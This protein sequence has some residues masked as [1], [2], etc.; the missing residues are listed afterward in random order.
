V[1]VNFSS[2]EEKLGLCGTMNVPDNQK[3]N[4]PNPPHLPKSAKERAPENSQSFRRWLTRR[5]LLLF[6]FEK[7]GSY[8]SFNSSPVWLLTRHY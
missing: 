1:E 6:L 2:I 7:G 5:V 4:N 8:F 3:R